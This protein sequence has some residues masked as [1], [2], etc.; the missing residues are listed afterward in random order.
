M[1]GSGK[2]GDLSPI[3]L[4]LSR[5]SGFRRSRV[6]SSKE[7]RGEVDGSSAW[8]FRQGAVAHS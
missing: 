4:K 3:K 7:Y 1:N 8:R 5:K 2:A 6:S